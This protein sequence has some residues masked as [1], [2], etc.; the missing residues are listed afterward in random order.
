MIKN[1]I[2]RHARQCA[3]AESCGY[4]VRT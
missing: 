1:D 4:I 2:L 3:P